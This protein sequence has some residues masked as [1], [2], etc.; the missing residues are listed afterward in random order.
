MQGGMKPVTDQ[1][2]Q[3]STSVSAHAPMTTSH[4]CV[5]PSDGGPPKTLET[6]MY[7]ESAV[8]MLWSWMCPGTSPGNVRPP[9]L[10]CP[11]SEGGFPSFLSGSVPPAAPCSSVSVPLVHISTYFPPFLMLSLSSCFSA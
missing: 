6:S 5:T 4:L 3:L 1:G 7:R 9:R 8:A 2:V 11:Q 10:F